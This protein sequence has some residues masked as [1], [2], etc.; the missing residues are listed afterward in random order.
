MG[1]TLIPPIFQGPPAPQTDFIDHQKKPSYPWNS[2]FQS[3]AVRLTR[4][5]SSVPPATSTSAGSPGQIAFDSGFLYVCIAT[6]TWRRVAL[7][8]F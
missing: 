8:V 2:W 5:V 6:N 7:A 1:N 3:V 4:I